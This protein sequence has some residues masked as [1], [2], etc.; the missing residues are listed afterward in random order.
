MLWS[1]CW[2]LSRSIEQDISWS[3]SW[4]VVGLQSFSQCVGSLV[5]LLVH[6]C[7]GSLG[8]SHSQLIPH[9]VFLLVSWSSYLVS[10]AVCLPI[11]QSLT[12]SL[13]GCWS[14]CHLFCRSVG[15]QVVC[16]S[17]SLTFRRFV[18]LAVYLTVHWPWLVGPLKSVPQVPW[19]VCLAV[20]LMFLLVGLSVGQ[21]V[22]WWDSQLGYVCLSLGSLVSR[23]ICWLAC[24]FVCWSVSWSVPCLS[25]SWCFSVAWFF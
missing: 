22:G 17:V 20:I 12:W 24:Q 8:W 11:H 13:I 21:S 1:I 2:L 7:D 23:L 25:V 14:L 5:C 15:L 9:P 10:Q 6:L 4:A 18:G 3:L 16:W 19:S